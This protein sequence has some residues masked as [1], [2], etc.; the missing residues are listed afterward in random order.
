MKKNIFLP[1]LLAFFVFVPAMLM[2]A[3]VT[4]S[5]GG[6]IASLQQAVEAVRKIEKLDKPIVV[7]FQGGVYP[8]TEPVVFKS[9]DSGTEKAPVVYRA[10]Q[11]QDVVFS[12][13]RK[14]TGWK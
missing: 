12:G 10:A 8:M 13:G 4:V 2:A 9:E 7:E 11:G 3:D 14:I 6:P 5:P 1:F